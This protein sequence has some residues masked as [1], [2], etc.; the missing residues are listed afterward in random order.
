MAASVRALA[1]GKRLR[2]EAFNLPGR[3]AMPYKEKP[4]SLR[5]FKQTAGLAET[6]QVIAATPEHRA[7]A[8]RFHAVCTSRP[9]L[10][11]FVPGEPNW[12]PTPTPKSRAT[13]K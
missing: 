6:A 9:A 4:D 10:S 3:A 1:H 2:L 7:H 11:V 5:M 12:F 8:A 13:D